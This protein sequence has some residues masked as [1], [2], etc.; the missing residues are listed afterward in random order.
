M[1][2]SHVDGFGSD[3]GVGPGQQLLDAGCWLEIDELSERVGEPRLRID[4]AELTGFDQRADDCPVGN[5]FVRALNGVG[6]DLEAAIIEERTNP[7]PWL[8]P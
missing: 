7:S 1:R 4:V 6:V 2:R 5:A 3:S 8:R